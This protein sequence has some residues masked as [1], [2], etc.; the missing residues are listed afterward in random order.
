MILSS[1]LSNNRKEWLRIANVLIREVP[2][3][4]EQPAT[5]YCSEVI[6]HNSWLLSVLPETERAEL[7]DN[8]KTGHVIIKRLF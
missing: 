3:K 1:Q 8:I 4:F 2:S 7:V 5:R 6:D